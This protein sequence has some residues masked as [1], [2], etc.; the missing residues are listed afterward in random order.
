[1]LAAI[2]MKK[3]TA[4][5]EGAKATNS[6]NR[7]RPKKP[8]ATKATGGGGAKTQKSRNSR[9]D[10]DAG[11][12]S[13]TAADKSPVRAEVTREEEPGSGDNFLRELGEAALNFLPSHKTKYSNSPHWWDSFLLGVQSDPETAREQMRMMGQIARGS[14]QSLVEWAATTKHL[15]EVQTWA[16]T[17]LADVISWL[18]EFGFADLPKSPEKYGEA[19]QNRWSELHPDRRG[20]SG[21]AVVRCYASELICMSDNMLE[22]VMDAYPNKLPQDA[23]ASKKAVWAFVDQFVQWRFR[24]G[25]KFLD[26]EE[27]RSTFHWFRR[28]DSTQERYFRQHLRPLIRETWPKWVR[29]PGRVDFEGYGKI[30]MGLPLSMAKK[31]KNGKPALEPSEWE[32]RI[33]HEVK[34]NL[35]FESLFHG[36]AIQFQSEEKASPPS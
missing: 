7:T 20:T 32:D 14:I 27:V 5:K 10:S 8:A 16:Q 22:Q 34:D 36:E 23:D 30:K 6:D 15:P 31:G 19:F 2:A 11:K 12:N 24:S 35:R 21:Y 25:V 1:M 29:E 26:H 28:K 4:P 33:I 18:Q 17:C 3:N 13:Q 9:L